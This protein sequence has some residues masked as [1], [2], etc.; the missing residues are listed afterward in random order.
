MVGMEYFLSRLVDMALRVG[1]LQRK[2]LAALPDIESSRPCK[3]TRQ[4]PPAVQTQRSRYVMDV[5]QR[6]SLLN[7]CVKPLFATAFILG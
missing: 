6:M 3:C 7:C 5:E 2:E 4:I 1:F